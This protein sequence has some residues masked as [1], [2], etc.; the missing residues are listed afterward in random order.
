M[1]ASWLMSIIT[2]E[3]VEERGNGGERNIERDSM[4]GSIDSTVFPLA[5]SGTFV[6]LFIF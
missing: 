2:G 1:H 5:S 4:E 3:K 6:W